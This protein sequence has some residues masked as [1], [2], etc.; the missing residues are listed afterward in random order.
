MTRSGAP[1]HG[2]WSAGFSAGKL[3]EEREESMQYLS[4]IVNPFTLNM[5]SGNAADAAALIK[6]AAMSAGTS[7]V[8]PVNAL[9]AA[10]VALAVGAGIYI[11]RHRRIGS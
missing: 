9:I 7:A 2:S 8:D 6:R 5:V 4:Y 10:A 3:F 11:Y 1:L